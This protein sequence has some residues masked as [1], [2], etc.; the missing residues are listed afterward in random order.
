MPLKKYLTKKSK[1]VGWKK[2][3]KYCDVVL[4]SSSGFTFRPQ[5]L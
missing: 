1:Y 3:I 2:K 4:D 5:L